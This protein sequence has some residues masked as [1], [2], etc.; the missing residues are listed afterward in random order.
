M[1]RQPTAVDIVCVRT[2]ATRE[3]RRRESNSE[4]DIRER[5]ESAIMT[6]T[7]GDIFGI[8]RQ[9]CSRASTFHRLTPTMVFSLQYL[10]YKYCMSRICQCGVDVLVLCR[11][12]PS[13]CER[14]KTNFELR[15]ADVK[16]YLCR[17][18][19]ADCGF[20]LASMKYYRIVHACAC[21]YAYACVRVTRNV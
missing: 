7:R 2:L 10:P 3:E 13:V 1:H 8:E 14:Q 9:V 20:A 11:A 5:N 19:Y 4:T 17:A 16:I 15:T 12:A 21:A 18:K 6:R